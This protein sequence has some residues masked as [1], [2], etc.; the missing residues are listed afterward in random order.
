MR[1]TNGMMSSRF[2]K[3]V[4]SNLTNLSKLNR[5]L[6]SGKEI[7]RPSDD[8]FKVARSM[9][10]H[11]DIG[12]NTQYNTN[13]T[14]TINW[15]DTTDTALD[16]LNNTFQRVREL[17][18][19]AGNAS[20]GPDER[21][22]IRDEINERVNEAAQI[23]NTSFD[24]KYVF[25]GTK[26]NSKPLGTEIDPIT[27]SNEIYLSGKDGEKLFLD[28]T[29]KNIKNQIG[30]I[31]SDLN[32]EISK[33][34]SVEYGVSAMDV[35]MFTDSNGKEVNVMSLFKEIGDNL[36]SDDQSKID[37]VTNEGLAAM[38]Q[39][40]SNLLKVRSEVGSMQN[41]MESAKEQN[42]AENFNMT[43][44]LSQTEDIDIA[45]KTMEATVAQ[46][47]YIASLQTGAKVLQP[48]LMDFLR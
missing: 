16:Q 31:K 37:K 4:R 13:I 6:T 23:M 17:M 5:Q 21:K 7:S 36:A 12:A 44:I 43:D 34:V 26:T 46:T 38:D 2:L 41:R 19:S 20:Y 29:E 10:L 27:G 9:Q 14:D 39:V 35:L 32:V 3:D 48:S 11:S 18:V 45:E 28:S 15:L 47:A 24:G 33:G 40:M 25:G 1:V 30:M 42:E 8:P 22:A